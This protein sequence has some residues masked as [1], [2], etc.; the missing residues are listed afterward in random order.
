MPRHLVWFR[1]DLR[2]A[3]NAALHAA[4]H[5]APDAGV[6]GVFIISP[7]EWTAHDVAPVRVEFILRTLG[8]LSLDLKRRNIPL[9]IAAAPTPRDVP[10]VLCDLARRHNATALYFNREYE[11]NEA[12]RDQLVIA[13][14]NKLGIGCRAFDD[15]VVLAPGSVRTQ[16][17]RAYTVF[18]PFKKRWMAV[19][20][21]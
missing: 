7:G 19:L 14:M 13:G 1:S 4:T 12:R 8:V 9:L 6:I 16:D 17:D 2:V 15:Q 20:G 11:V 10:G 18:T 3:D 5:P 21:E